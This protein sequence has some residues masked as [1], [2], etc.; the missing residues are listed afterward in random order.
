[1]NKIVKKMIVIVLLFCTCANMS[2]A[3]YPV[4]DASVLY[5]TLLDRMAQVEHF[6]AEIEQWKN[7]IEH[8][9]RQYEQIQEYY[10]QLQGIIEKFQDCQSLMDYWNNTKEMLNKLVQINKA[11]GELETMLFGDGIK[12]MN[13]NARVINELRDMGNTEDV[14]ESIKNNAPNRGIYYE[15]IFIAAVKNNANALG[16][17]RDKLD[18]CIQCQSVLIDLYTKKIEE[19]DVKIAEA[20]YRWLKRRW[21]VA[22]YRNQGE[23]IRKSI[24]DL[25][26]VLGEY[27]TNQMELYND[28]KNTA[29]EGA[30]AEAVNMSVSLQNQR[31]N[32]KNQLDSY[33]ENIEEFDVEI[34]ILEET[35]QELKCEKERWSSSLEVAR[36]NYDKFMKIE[37]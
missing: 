33:N 22:D 25:D 26:N 18:K 9:K 21:E 1:M 19:L 8:Y 7:V 4:S 32:L 30:R 2:F 37:L 31:E 20:E 15:R 36:F 5:Q 23:L 14:V 13:E 3:M 35:V 27:E 16:V 10:K 6:F 12:I 34:E 17:E 29:T 11:R 24:R 28:P